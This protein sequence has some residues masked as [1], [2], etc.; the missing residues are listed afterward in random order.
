MVR[1][2][3]ELVLFRFVL[4]FVVGGIV[5]VME[6]HSKFWCPILGVINWSLSRLS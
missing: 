2:V 3:S 5:P 6:D 1:A 4:S